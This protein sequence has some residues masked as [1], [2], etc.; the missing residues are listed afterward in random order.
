[1]A[2]NKKENNGEKI[3]VTSENIDSLDFIT[4][5][6]REITEEA[7]RTNPSSVVYFRRI[8]SHTG[9][10]DISFENIQFRIFDD[11]YEEG[12]HY[13]LIFTENGTDE[14]F[15]TT[16]EDRGRTMGAW[17]IG[18]DDFIESLLDMVSEF[19]NLGYRASLLGIHTRWRSAEWL[20]IEVITEFGIVREVVFEDHTVYRETSKKGKIE[21]F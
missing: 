7:L 20:M 10:L 6:I 5:P 21:F 16:D 4:S 3:L 12:T 14:E 13:K 15:R 8:N 11:R 18:M 1:M 19:E 9:I 17:I 2:E